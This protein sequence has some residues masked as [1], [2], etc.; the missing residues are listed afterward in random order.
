MVKFAV[1][2]FAFVITGC[3]NNNSNPLP[4]TKNGPT[5]IQDNSVWYVVGKTCDGRDLLHKEHRVVFLKEFLVYTLR[6]SENENSYCNEG[7]VYTRVV[8]EQSG[9]NGYYEKSQLKPTGIKVQCRDKKTM[10]VISSTEAPLN[11][12]GN[13]IVELTLKPEGSTV[14]WL[15]SP[16]CPEGV[17]NLQLAGTK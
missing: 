5:K 8:L 7:K 15:R 4:D 10:D 12:S 13:Q 3:G 9:S 1:F 16:L 2:I 11:E 6:I 14:T 17:L